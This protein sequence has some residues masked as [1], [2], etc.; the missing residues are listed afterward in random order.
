MC[1]PV[2]VEFKKPCSFLGTHRPQADFS[3]GAPGASPNPAT[4]YHVNHGPYGFL[5]TTMVE[6]KHSSCLFLGCVD[7]E[8]DLFDFD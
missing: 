8:V 3:M 4:R 6:G 1:F 5:C 2:F 7:S